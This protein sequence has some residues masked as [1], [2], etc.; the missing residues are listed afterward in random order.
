G[1]KRMFSPKTFVRTGA[2][3]LKLTIILPIAYYAL[4]KFAPS[5]VMLMHLNLSQ[6]FEFTTDALFY[7]FWK[8]LYVLIAFALFDYF[9]SK[10]QWL[11]QNRMTKEEVKDERKSIEGDEKTKRQIQA[12]GLQ[13]IMERIQNSVPQAD[14]IITNPTH[15]SIALKYDRES[16]AAPKVIAKGK[17]FLALRIRKIAKAHGIPILERKLL[18]RA[19]Y[20]SCEVGTEIPKDMFKAVAQVLAYVY[21]LKNP[22]AARQWSR[23]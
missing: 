13:R 3:I 9:Y 11:R 8:I 16:M 7:V 2:S 23:T 1:V 12:K 10:W 21:K 22:H 6:I 18:A 20:A 5:M 4:K 14:V 19:L 17:G 15:Y